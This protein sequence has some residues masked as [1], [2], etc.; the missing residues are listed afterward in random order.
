MSGTGVDRGSRFYYSNIETIA[1][2]EARYADLSSEERRELE[3][4]KEKAADFKRS[5]PEKA[6]EAEEA[7]AK[8][9][10]PLLMRGSW[11]WNRRR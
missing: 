5:Y 11:N 4:S 2:K 7:L 1:A 9:G 6:K 10:N 3:T 8:N